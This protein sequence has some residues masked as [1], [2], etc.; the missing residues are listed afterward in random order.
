M[1]RVRINGEKNSLVK[2]HV[3]YSEDKNA[4]P[5][6]IDCHGGVRE[7]GGLGQFGRRE[8]KVEGGDLRTRVRDRVRGKEA[9]EGILRPPG[10]RPNETLDPVGRSWWVFSKGERGREIYLKHRLKWNRRGVQRGC[11]FGREGDKPRK[12]TRRFKIQRGRRLQK[13]GKHTW[14]ATQLMT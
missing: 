2:S 10:R 13:G 5:T 12:E 8:E 4:T 11:K 7:R 3:Q 1:E 6:S 14:L 9:V